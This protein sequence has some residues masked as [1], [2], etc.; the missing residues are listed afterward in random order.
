MARRRRI[1]PASA[2]ESLSPVLIIS[3][4]MALQTAFYTVA[5]LLL[6]FTAVVIGAR[7]SLDLP[8]SWGVVTAENAA[9]WTVGMVWLLNSLTSVIA[10][11]LFVGRTKLV[12][13]FS[14]TIYFVHLL[15]TSLYSRSVPASWLWWA[16][17]AASVV[18]TVSLATW[19][20]R[21][22]ELQ[23]LSWGNR[24]GAA[25]GAGGGSVV[26]VGVGGGM[27]TTAGEQGA[28]HEM[29]P[30]KRDQDVV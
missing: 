23:P 24:R 29:V 7:F 22:R 17:Q 5:T 28:G 1:R 9:G 11:T 13:D 12:L 4:I 2:L 10:I 6:L 15:V 20:C 19:L 14:L 18:I 21:K 30:L 27:V 8:F 26:G 25:R 16:V 3:Q